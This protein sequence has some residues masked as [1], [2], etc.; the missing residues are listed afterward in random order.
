[1]DEFAS[2]L[3]QAAIKC[4]NVLVLGDS[5]LDANKW[6]EEKFLHRKVSIILRDTLEANDM[7]ILKVANHVQK[8][9][10]IAVSAIDHVYNSSNIDNFGT[11]YYV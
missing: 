10:N 3:E 1:M 8:N 6:N 11:T 7:K 2:Q 5:N 4:K 9:G